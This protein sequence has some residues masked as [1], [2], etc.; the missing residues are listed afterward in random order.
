VFKQDGL[1]LEI[2]IAFRVCFIRLEYGTPV[3]IGQ[4]ASP[5]GLKVGLFSY[6]YRGYLFPTA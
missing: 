5:K 3:M 6:L 1:Y 2:I 4:T